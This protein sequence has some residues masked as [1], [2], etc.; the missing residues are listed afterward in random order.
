MRTGRM[1]EKNE[2]PNMALTQPLVFILCTDSIHLCE[3]HYLKS[4]EYQARERGMKWT[5]IFSKALPFSGDIRAWTR[6][7]DSYHTISPGCSRTLWGRPV[8]SRI[9]S[10]QSSSTSYIQGG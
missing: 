7:A 6:R 1:C 4:S 10:G 2:I 9:W 5:K 8:W 3:V